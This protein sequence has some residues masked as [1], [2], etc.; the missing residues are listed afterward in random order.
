MDLA[1]PQCLA[2][3]AHPLA[4]RDHRVA[5]ALEPDRAAVTPVLQ[6]PDAAD[7]RGGQDRAASAGRLALIVEADVAGHDREVERTARLRHPLDAADELAHD[8]RVLRVAE[9]HAVGRGE[10]DRADRGDVAPRLGDRLLPALD[11]VGEAIARRA[12]GGDRQRLVG[13][14]DPHHR[15]VAAGALDGVGADLAVILL[16]DPAAAGEVGRAHQHQQVGGDIAARRHVGQRCGQRRRHVRP[17]V[18]R[19]LVGERAERDVAHHLAP[20]AQHHPPGIGD[21]ADHR[22]I[23]LPFAEDRLRRRLSAGLQ[24]HEHP[25]LA[26]RQHHLVGGHADL[27][28]RHVV[29]HQLDADAALA[30]HLDAGGGEAGGAHV[31]DRDDRVG[32][33]QL[34]TGLDQ[35]L[36]GEGVADLH[37]GPLRL[38]VLAEV[39]A[40]HGRAV[41]AVAAGLGP[42]IDDRV[43][44]AGGRRIEDAVGVGHADG[45]RVD[46]DVAVIGGVEVHLAADGG[47]ADAVAIAADAVDD[48]GDQVAHP[49]VVGPAETQRVH[50]GDRPRAHGEHVA[51]DA[52]DPGRRALVRLDVRGVVVRLHLED[53]RL[54][55][56]DVD[57][58]GV[59]AWAADHL[60]TG[61]GQLLEVEAARFVAAMLGPHDR[62]D[63][64]LD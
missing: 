44:N 18:E 58:A 61:S 62:E 20:V 64:E 26:F 57:D 48:A 41:D 29:H 6:Q 47:H 30:G 9:V 49:G 27:A 35:Q 60:R 40:R 22:E 34:Q 8:P 36:F 3:V 13:A 52:A 1:Q 2:E 24:H 5:Q 23:Q 10:R 45:H 21:V 32:R 28:L 37:G 4:D 46:Q 16:P 25:L 51:Q 39:R 56:A 7:R 43:A 50:V 15:G 54:A 17:V 53:R 33:H 38:R 59:L 12:V 14:V 42:H 11:R 63:A 55:V 19:R 31:L